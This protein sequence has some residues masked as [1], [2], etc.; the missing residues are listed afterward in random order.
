MRAPLLL[1]QAVGSLAGSLTTLARPAS[2]NE[3]S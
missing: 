3:S 1:L 2:L